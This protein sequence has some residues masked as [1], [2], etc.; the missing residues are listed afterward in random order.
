MLSE[1]RAT[2]RYRTYR[3]IRLQKPGVPQVI[4]TITKDLSEGGLRCI[5]QTVFPVSTEL[6]IDLLL[7]SGDEPFTAKGRTAWFRMIPNSD[8]FDVGVVFLEVTPKSK[9]LLSIC[10][11]RLAHQ[12]SYD[13]T[14]V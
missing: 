7:V 11:D 9:R 2:P 5:S 13:L 8:Q 6:R 3:P 12:S 4:E 14:A 10:I 1:R